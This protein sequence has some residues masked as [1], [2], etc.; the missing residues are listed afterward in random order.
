MLGLLLSLTGVCT[1]QSSM[2]LV[3]SGSSQRIQNRH[4]DLDGLSRMTGRSMILRFHRLG[5]L[6]RLPASTPTYYLRAIPPPYRYLRPWSKA[7]LERL[8]RRFHSR[9]GKRLRVTSLIRG[10][11]RQRALARRNGNAAPAFGIN[12]STHLTGAT[13]DISKAYMTGRE[14][15]W[16]RRVLYSM[17]KQKRIYA[18]EEFRQPTFHIMVYRSYLDPAK[19]PGA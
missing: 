2:L 6:E 17:K 14:K 7:F 5:Y 3:A 12:R 16:M 18:V 13:F 11:E 8:S 10:I 15:A 1:A 19:G 4:A 9:F